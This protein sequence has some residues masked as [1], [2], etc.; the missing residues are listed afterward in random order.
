MRNTI[1]LFSI[2]SICTI[3]N[4]QKLSTTELSAGL[5]EALTV[6]ANNASKAAQQQD[7]FFKNEKIKIPFPPEAIALKNTL[8]KMGAQN[9]TEKLIETLNRGAEEA[10]KNASPILIDAIKSITIEDGANILHGNDSAATQYLKQHT[11]TQLQQTFKPTVVAALKKVEV[12][13]YWDP[14]VSK[15]NK[16]PFVKKQNA[17]LETYVTNKAI[18]GLFTLIAGEEQN[19][20]QHP[21]AQTSKLLKTMFKTGIKE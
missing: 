11:L 3:V 15:Y 18:D 6:S 2:L 4:A 19:I 17:D 13:K 21:V 20:R 14:L 8:D 12:T 5:K 10:C 9:E 7:G 1:L 16:I